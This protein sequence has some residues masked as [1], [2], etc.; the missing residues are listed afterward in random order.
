[1]T[2]SPMAAL[3][4][5]DA[6]PFRLP[7]SHFAVALLFLVLGALGLV[8]ISPDL[9]AG[10]F[11]SP[12]V[13]G[14]THLFTL[15]WITTSIMGA[16]YQLLPVALEREVRW[17]RVAQGTLLLYA[18]GLLLFVAGVAG[19]SREWILPGAVL[20]A[21]GV[22]TFALNLA[23]T[24]RAAP[25]RD[26]TWRALALADGFLVVTVVL[27]VAL[28]L[29]LQ[30]D[31]MGAHRLLALPVHLHVALVGWVLLVMVG[32]AQR[33]LPMFLLS[34]GADERPG[35]WAVGL[36]ALGAGLLVA[37][38]HAPGP[39]VR[40][41]PAPLMLAGVGAFLLQAR[42][43]YRH[44]RRPSLDPG[45][46]SAA[47][48]LAVVGLAAA[49]GTLQAVTG[50]GRPLLATA[51]VA[52]LVL[53]ITLFVAALYYKIVPF[54]VWYHRFAP[55]AGKGPVPMVAELYHSGWAGAAGLLLAGGGVTSAAGIALGTAPVVRA[56]ASAFL[57]GAV[58]LAAQMAALSRR[59]PS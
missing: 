28:A 53:G 16:L 36:L 18:P 24:L 41:V 43:F 37:L 12:R 1:M 40:L 51:Y 29:N 19:G 58:V 54:L 6:P 42:G 47:A 20:L 39:V 44:R 22:L 50:F 30:R 55:R 14:V 59:I 21:A 7:G 17:P 13:A 57:A 35:R 48:A 31:F 52:L 34:H 5:V 46:R 38:H 8:W 27:G 11:L 2:P 45:M 4:G 3:T 32:V 56:G 10:A 23:A 33:L 49:L 15:G 25:R 26:L 9:A